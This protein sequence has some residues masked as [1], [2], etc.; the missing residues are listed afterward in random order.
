MQE[1][2]AREMGRLVKDVNELLRKAL[3]NPDVSFATQDA[4][5]RLQQ[6][7]LKL[8]T[9]VGGA[10]ARR[11]TD[12]PETEAADSVA[13][14][15]ALQSTLGPIADP[16]FLMSSRSVPT[17]V[18]VTLLVLTVGTIAGALSQIHQRWPTAMPDEMVS[19]ER[20]AVYAAVKHHAEVATRDRTALESQLDTQKTELTQLERDRGISPTSAGEDRAAT[21]ALDLRI[22]AGQKKVADGK[23]Q[24]DAAVQREMKWW[25]QASAA[26]AGIQPSGLNVLLM[27]ILFG[28][29]GGALHLASSLTMYIGNRD[30]KRS[31][32]VYYL[33]APVQGAALAPLMYLLLKSAILAPQVGGGTAA[34]NLTAIYGVSG[35]TGLFAK[36]AIERLA[37]VFAA[38]FAKVEAKDTTKAGTIAT[39]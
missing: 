28:A 5:T 6:E 29:L 25:T 22:A 2:N 17:W 21:E 16:S 34:L 39:T 27:V 19:A 8:P 36:Q 26:Q 35:L 38:M 32:I 30:F 24:M 4:A 15:Q 20:Q 12:V 14:L 31:W 23:L 37:A 33:L 11:W 13:Q 3:E 18:I 10:D 7:L 1:M 9:E